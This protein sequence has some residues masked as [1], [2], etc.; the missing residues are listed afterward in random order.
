MRSIPPINS[1]RSRP[2]TRGGAVRRLLT[3]GAFALAAL[4]VLGGLVVEESG[5]GEM[6]MMEVASS[7]SGWLHTDGGVIRDAANNPYIIK[8]ISWFGLETPECVPHGLWT[9]NLEEGIQQIKDMGFNTIRL[10]YSNECITTGETSSVDSSANPG[11]VGKAP[12]HVM[13]AVIAA[14]KANGLNVILDRHRPDSGSQSELWYTALYSEEKWIADWTML[15]ARYKDNP[16]VIGAD[17]HNEPRGAACWGCENP[18]TD[19]QAAATR[20][21][22]SILSIN[23]NLLIIVEGIENE[24]DGTAT[25][26]GSGL[27]GVAAY[28]IRLDIDNRVVYSP[29]DYPGSVYPQKWF[30]EPDYPANLPNVWDNNWGY[31]AKQGI[32]PVLLGEFGTRLE[33]TSDKQW[34]DQMVKYLGSTG[35][36]YSYWSY[37]PNSGDTGGLVQD[38]WRTPETTKLEALKPLLTTTPVP[39]QPPPAVVTPEILTTSIPTISGTNKVGYTLTANPRTWTTGTRLTYQWYRSGLPIKGAASKSYK[40]VSADRDSTVKV[41]V[42]G[43]RTGYSTVP[44]YSLPTVRISSS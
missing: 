41:R 4:P 13:D 44:K 42:V 31:I 22:N 23:P 34:L 3:A 2:P 21:G 24:S 35:I 15:A 7:T 28:P 27:K 1:M 32:A 11:L 19:W 17:L 43:S 40:L 18:A 20:A 9:I 5:M 16:T 6:R 12:L 37:N 10:P 29:H 25:W 36:S 39:V 33:T 26:W 30:S 38:D 14:A 8:S